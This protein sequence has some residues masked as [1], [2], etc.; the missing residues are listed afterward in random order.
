MNKYFCKITL[1]VSEPSA[2]DF[3]KDFDEPEGSFSYSLCLILVTNF[4]GIPWRISRKCHE[5]HESVTDITKLRERKRQI[6]RYV[7][8]VAERG[9]HLFST[10]C[11]NLLEQISRIFWASLTG[12]GHLSDLKA[13]VLQPTASKTHF[14]LWAQF[15]RPGAPVI[16]NGHVNALGYGP[17]WR[18]TRC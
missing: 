9:F 14:R 2:S 10:G 1:Q 11:R 5:F 18:P 7:R 4:T 17:R 6:I 3:G 8:G 15:D 13:T 16:V 12:L